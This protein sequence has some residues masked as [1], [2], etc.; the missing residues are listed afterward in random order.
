MCTLL[1]FSAR[2]TS[3]DKIAKFGKKIIPNIH[4]YHCFR[5]FRSELYLLKYAGHTSSNKQSCL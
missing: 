3:M 5:I 2:P 4:K 1:K